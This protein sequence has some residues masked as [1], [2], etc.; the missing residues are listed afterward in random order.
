MRLQEELSFEKKRRP[1]TDSRTQIVSGAAQLKTRANT[2]ELQ[3]SL[4]ICSFPT[5]NKSADGYRVV[6]DFVLEQSLEEKLSR[7]AMM[8]S[9]SQKHR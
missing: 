3:L 7:L 8:H 1:W 4:E 5:H 6:E 2:N 9:Q